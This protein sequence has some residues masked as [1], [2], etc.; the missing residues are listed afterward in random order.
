M[1]TSYFQE[2]LQE[3]SSLHAFTLYL[4]CWQTPGSKKMPW[5]LDIP[6]R[7]NWTPWG[8]PLGQ[9]VFQAEAMI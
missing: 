5:A 6:A 7:A 4:G 3:R 2:V 8:G 9:L 1:P